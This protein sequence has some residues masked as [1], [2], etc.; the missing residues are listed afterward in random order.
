MNRVYAVVEGQTEESFVRDVLAKHLVRRNVHIEPILLT[1]KRVK[2]RNAF[3]RSLPGRRFKGGVSSYNQ[4]KRDIRNVLNDRGV[5]AVT[6]MIDFYGLPR[7]FPGM[8][9]TTTRL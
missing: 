2:N 5:A 4:V 8:N 3:E 6:T 1:T 9:S 7:D